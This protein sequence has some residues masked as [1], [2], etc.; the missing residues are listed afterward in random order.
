MR[1][2]NAAGPDG[3]LDRSA[4]PPSR[5]SPE[6][7]ADLAAKVEEGPDRAVKGF[8]RWR[9]VDPRRIIGAFPGSLHCR[10]PK[11]APFRWTRRGSCA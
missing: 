10:R 9:H 1:R 2:F 11:S 6:R 3:L 4:G 7:R 8:M 5:L